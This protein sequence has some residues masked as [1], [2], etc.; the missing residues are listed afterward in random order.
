MIDFMLDF[1]PHPRLVIDEVRS[2]TDIETMVAIH[3][4]GF[5][6]GWGIDEIERLNAE[7]TVR[8][9]LLRRESPFGIRRVLG[10]IMVRSVAGEAEVL[11]IAV[12]E[13]RRGRGYGRRLIEEALRR[14]Y[15][16]GA[17]RVFLEVGESNP[18]ALALY[19]RIGFQE[20]G[21]RK[22]YY[23]DGGPGGTALVMQLQLR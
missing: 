4:E 6:R 13:A 2:E 9:L 19:R 14:L 11:T 3:A 7:P 1:L 12:A 16:E 22:G 18:P 5:R 17:E 8:C 21:R 15:A 20:V 10:F 23:A